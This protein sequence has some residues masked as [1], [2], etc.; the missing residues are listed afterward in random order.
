MTTK[1]FFGAPFAKSASDRWLMPF[2]PNDDDDLG[3]EV[4]PAAYS[5]DRSRKV[6]GV[7]AWRDYL[8]HGNAL[9]A[10]ASSE[11]G[12]RGIITCFPQ[13]PVA[14]GLRKRLAR[15]DTPLVA[16][17]FNLGQLYPGMRQRLSRATLSAVDRF[18]VHSR[19]EITAYSEW[20]DLPAE[21]FRFVPLQRVTKP[22]E[23]SEDVEKPFLLSMGSARRDYR[24]LFE[25]VRELGFRT[26]VVAGEHAVAGL[27]IPPNVEI[28]SGLSAEQC[29]ELV[30]RA[31][32]SVVPIS[33]RET[34]SGQVTLLEAMAYARSVII[35]SCPASI[36]Y[37]VD[38]KDALLVRLG[39]HD[40][41]K[42][43]IRRLWEDAATRAE[44][45]SAAHRSA[46][47][48][49][50]DEAIGKAMGAILREFSR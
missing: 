26:V 3:F 48:K 41:L 8:H 23:F 30:Q 22:I 35:T 29:A 33:N 1:W 21:R 47:E 28:R 24:L 4:V 10:A 50:S 31:R 5:H 16:W 20:L 39:D 14:V 7:D 36:D 37:V 2:V 27:A 15:S 32:F 6:T 25:V 9:W 42:Q 18:I 45:G 17:T 43:A 34:A 38:G 46:V 19:A 40:D 49:F 44:I 11:S 12:R 13:L